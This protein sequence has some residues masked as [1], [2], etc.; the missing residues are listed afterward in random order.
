VDVISAS[1]ILWIKENEPEI[2][3][4]TARFG[5]YN[6]YLVKRLRGQ[7]PIDPSTTSIIGLYNTACHHLTWNKDLLN[8]SEIP[9]TKLPPII[10][11]HYKAGKILPQIASELR[12]PE[13]CDVMS[14]PIGAY[15]LSLIQE[16]R[17]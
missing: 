10:K 16:E 11:S 4:A 6:T 8:L 14:F 13:D 7:W 5:H 17:L 12:L 9:E 3:K 15:F 2:W 1:F